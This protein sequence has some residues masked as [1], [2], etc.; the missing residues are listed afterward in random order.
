MSAR[1]KKGGVRS[2]PLLAVMLTALLALVGVGSAGAAFATSNST[3]SINVN[4]GSLSDHECNSSEWHFVITQVASEEQA[5]ASISVSF[6][7]GKTISVSLDKVTGGTAHYATTQYLDSKVVSATAD[8]YEGWSGT[9]NLSH[10]PCGNDNPPPPPPTTIDNPSIT[11]DGVCGVNNDT[12]TVSESEDYTSSEPVWNNSQVSVTFTIKEGL[13]KVFDNGE[14]T[15]TITADEVNTE[16]C[17]TPPPPPTKVTNPD[18]TLTGVCGVNNDTV[19]ASSTEDYTAGKPVWKDSKVSV[20]FTIRDGVNKVFENGEKSIT[21][22]KDEVNTEDC[23][24]PPPPPTTIDDPSITLDGVCG[25]N[26][27]TVTVSESEDYTSSEPVWN[28][29]QVSVTFTIKEGLNKVFDNGEKTIT[30]TAD[31][32][33][34][35]DCTTPPPPPTTSPL[36]VNFTGFPVDSTFTVYAVYQGEEFVTFGPYPT[37]NAQPV[38]IPDKGLYGFTIV[39]ND[40]DGNILYQSDEYNESTTVPEECLNITP[41]V[42]PPP[43]VKTLHNVTITPA[44]GYVS[45]TNPKSNPTVTVYYGSFD[46][47][48]PDGT[49]DVKPGKTVKIKTER[50]SLDGMVWADGYEPLVFENVKVQQNCTTPPPPHTTPQPPHHN[51]PVVHPHPVVHHNPAPWTPPTKQR[52][53]GGNTGV[54]TAVVAQESTPS[55]SLPIGLA[56]VAFLGVLAVLLGRR[57]HA[58]RHAKARS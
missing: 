27:D 36:C 13:N 6:D 45:V 48:E 47:M 23:T 28:N 51:P 49:V 29:S 22:T 4:P 19:N 32:V 5:P 24:T 57:R 35:E 39:V 58:P 25:V 30:I 56:V 52:T 37:A 46:Q 17:T 31:E 44:C 40:K 38:N 15:I 3:S 54:D 12:V 9:F 18:F 26:N 1:N 16:D 55:S 43:P 11:L 53:S 33:N 50:S 21:I 10:G 8:I 7:N 41:P 2:V 14:K 42:T 20:T 34:T